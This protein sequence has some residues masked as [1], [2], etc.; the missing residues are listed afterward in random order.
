[1]LDCC[2]RGAKPLSKQS[3]KT[4]PLIAFHLPNFVPWW[5]KS[6]LI[7]RI[8]L[9]GL[10]N[11]VGIFNQIWNMMIVNMATKIGS[12]MFPIF[13]ICATKRCFGNSDSGYKLIVCIFSWNIKSG[14]RVSNQTAK[15]DET[16]K[17]LL[18]TEINSKLELVEYNIRSLPWKKHA[19][20]CRKMVVYLWIFQS[21]NFDISRLP[22]LVESKNEL[23]QHIK[24]I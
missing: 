4:P 7:K 20:R 3:S 15:S 2:L 17:L 22:N 18:I 19:F 1:M 6:V 16:G 8:V 12:H 9:L 14:R 11:G 5:N 13:Y 23:I 21:S 10:K 24:A